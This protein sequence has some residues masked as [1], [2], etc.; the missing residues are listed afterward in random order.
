[1]ALKLSV[2]HKGT[3]PVLGPT[4][5]LKGPIP[6]ILVFLLTTLIKSLCPLELISVVK[7]QSLHVLLGEICDRYA[8]DTSSLDCKHKH[9]RKMELHLTY[10]ESCT[11]CYQY[12]NAS[13]DTYIY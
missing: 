5:E 4:H 8:Q 3:S 10:S 1:M 13:C 12:S 2:C 9:M 11:I 7:P 6:S